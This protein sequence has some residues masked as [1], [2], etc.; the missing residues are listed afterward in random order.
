MEDES[1]QEAI[2][3]YPYLKSVFQETINEPDWDNMVLNDEKT[4]FE[5]YGLIYL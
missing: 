5:E 4:G 1:I 3:N 2:K